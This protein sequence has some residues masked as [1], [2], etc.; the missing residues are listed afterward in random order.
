MINPSIKF[1]VLI[2]TGYDDED[3]KY[4]TKYTKWGYFGLVIGE[5]QGHWK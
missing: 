2:S 1:E 4:E 5:T 3:I